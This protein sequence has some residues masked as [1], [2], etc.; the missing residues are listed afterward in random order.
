M[1]AELYLEPK[2]GEGKTYV[3]WSRADQSTEQEHM[4]NLGKISYRVQWEQFYAEYLART[5]NQEDKLTL[6]DNEN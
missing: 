4:R 1:A 5:E 2:P 3:D 6:G